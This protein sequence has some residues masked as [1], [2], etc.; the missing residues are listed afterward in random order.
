M[1]LIT[2]PV[3][4]QSPKLI[5][6]SFQSDYAIAASTANPDGIPA[7]CQ[8]GGPGILGG[9]D[10]VNLLQ[11]TPSQLTGTGE[12]G[13][14]VEQ[15]NLSA[16][17]GYT[18]FSFKNFTT[19]VNDLVAFAIDPNYDKT[20]T[21]GI[22][23]V[24]TGLSGGTGAIAGA[25]TGNSGA[26]GVAMTFSTPMNDPT[27]AT[28]TWG[29]SAVAAVTKGQGTTAMQFTV[30][31]G[32]GSTGAKTVTMTVVNELGNVVTTTKAFTVS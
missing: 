12:Y 7:H 4:N 15:F 6:V 22:A 1:S 25:S 28:F 30:V 9:P 26:T 32:T 13:Y 2:V 29:G 20:F 23:Q 21:G 31:S 19:G 27:F 14:R 3:I 16:Y 17:P 24:P 11:R 10:Y 5:T 18:F 8:I